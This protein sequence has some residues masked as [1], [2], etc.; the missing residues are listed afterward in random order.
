MRAVNRHKAAVAGIE[1]G[2]A[3]EV[4]PENS[5]IKIFLEA[6]LLVDA[7]TI[8]PTLIEP[9]LDEMKVRLTQAEQLHESMGAQLAEARARI[10]ELE[11]QLAAK[12][13]STPTAE[14][15]SSP[16]APAK[17]GKG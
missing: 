5:G 1:P 6:G 15:A 11:A 4:D 14:P 8:V 3:G 7:D 2:C 16:E 9:T 17:K 10:A 12:A 13:E